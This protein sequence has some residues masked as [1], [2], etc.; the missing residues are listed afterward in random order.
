ML[1]EHIIGGSII[2]GFLKRLIVFTLLDYKH[3]LMERLKQWI[4]GYGLEYLGYDLF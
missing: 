3:L 2:Q 4:V 1:V